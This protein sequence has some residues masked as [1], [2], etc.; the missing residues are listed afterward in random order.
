MK[1]EVICELCKKVIDDPESSVKQYQLRECPECSG[2]PYDQ[3][4]KDHLYSICA[5][6]YACEEMEDEEF[7]DCFD[8][9]KAKYKEAHH[10]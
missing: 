5:K 4:P 1:K 2:K 9:S 10:L 7:E 6:C 3:I 8:M